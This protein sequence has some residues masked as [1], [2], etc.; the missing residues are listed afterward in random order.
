MSGR[1]SIDHVL[2]IKQP[3]FLIIVYRQLKNVI[4]KQKST[5][6]YR[7]LKKTMLRRKNLKLFELLVVCSSCNSENLSLFP[8]DISS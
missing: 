5:K 7:W 3:N 2:T 4:K 8:G 1:I 6:I